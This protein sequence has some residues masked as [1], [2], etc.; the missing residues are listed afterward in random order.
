VAD[1]A[2]ARAWLDT[3]RAS[4]VAVTVYAAA[5]GWAGHATRLSATLLRYLHNG[6]HFPEA[7]TVHS[8]ARD[9]A[10]RASDRA[11]EA[12]ALNGLGLVA[13]WQGRYE[14]AAVYLEQG[15]ALHRKTGDR[16]GEARAL[17]NLGSAST[18]LDASLPA[19]RARRCP[20]A[21]QSRC[22][23]RPSG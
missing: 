15:L 23:S 9:A 16:T 7:I 22:T 10:R 14:Q 5:N 3:Q 19:G 12:A 20:D 6:G 21:T 4:L 8:H 13:W 2:A 18:Y 1:P 17:S 11:A